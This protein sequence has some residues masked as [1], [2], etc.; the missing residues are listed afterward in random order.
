MVKQCIQFGLAA[1]V[2]LFLGLTEALAHAS[3]RGHV[4]LLPTNYYLVGGALAVLASFVILAFA[5]AAPLYALMAK[6]W[7]LPLSLRHGRVLVSTFSFCVFAVLVCAGWYGSRDPLANPLPLVFWSLLWVGLVIA[8][9]LLGNLWPWINPWYGPWR[10][11]TRLIGRKDKPLLSWPRALSFW[12][13]VAGLAA[14]AWFELAYP[15]PDDPS[16]LATV[17][18]SYWVLTFVAMLLF[19]YRPWS[20]RGEF[21]SLFL[22]MIARL[23]IFEHNRHRLNLRLPAAGLLNAPLLPVS[24][25]AFL[26][27]GLSSVTFDG[28]RQTF[29]W[30]GKIG[31]NPL[32]FPGRSAV[33]TETTVGLIG[34]FVLLAGAFFG[35]VALGHKLAGAQKPLSQALSP[36]VWT[37]VP[38]SFAYH[39]AHYLPS[40]LVDGQY[41]LVALSDP[42]ALGQN[43]FGTA[44]YHVQAGLISGADGAWAIWNIQAVTIVVGH[45]LAVIAAH[46]VA[47]RLYGDGRAAIRSQL[48]LVALMIA[49]TVIGLWLLSTP[50]SM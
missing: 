42:F 13:A 16:R 8:Q 27:L 39:L 21:L 33:V 40:L 4:L 7:P 15:A 10:I 22:S 5:P 34:A 49:Y 45:V 41:A 46:I 25:M 19:G 24:G 30:L 48:P 6:R 1:A 38:I 37:I 29:F 44:H 36:L 2:L 43:L 14:F 47:W 31:V 32:E 11:V 23:S 26:L 18:A 28:L 20:R 12:P 17:I 35:A 50:T 3:D 9:G